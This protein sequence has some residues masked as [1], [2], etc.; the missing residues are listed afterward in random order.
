MEWNYVS[1]Q[2]VL[3]C[4]CTFASSLTATLENLSVNLSLSLNSSNSQVAQPNLVVQSARLPAVVTE[5]VQFSAFSGLFIKNVSA[6][7]SLCLQNQ[8]ILRPKS[9]RCQQRLNLLK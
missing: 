7:K 1:M 3:S 8:L 4:L 6:L 2:M 5:G 9:T